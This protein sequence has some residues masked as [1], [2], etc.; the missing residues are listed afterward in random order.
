MHKSDK[1]KAH[2]ICMRRLLIIIMGILSF[3]M[4]KCNVEF[5][6]QVPNHH[7]KL[8]AGREGPLCRSTCG[9]SWYRLSRSKSNGHFLVWTPYVCVFSA[10]LNRCTAQK[11][12]YIDIATSPPTPPAQIATPSPAPAYYFG[13][14][15]MFPYSGPPFRKQ[16]APALCPRK[17]K[18]RIVALILLYITEEICLMRTWEITQIYYNLP[19]YKW[20]C[21][22][23]PNI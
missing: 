7:N 21:E 20:W 2:H 23:V 8:V 22:W 16:N 13:G 14:V 19:C 10:V 6:S 15:S 12:T 9:L 1:V 17:H 18:W 11:Q 5:Q 4:R 3:P